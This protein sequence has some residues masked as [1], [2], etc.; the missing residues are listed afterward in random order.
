MPARAAG[1]RRPR[2]R[3]DSILVFGDQLN[4]RMGAL[5]A[6]EPGEATVLLVE[7][8]ALLG[9]GRHVQRNHLVITAMR[10]F[11]R[12]LAAEGFDVDR[13]RAPTVRAGIEAHRA[14]RR[15]DRM[16]ATEPNSRRARALCDTLGIEQVRSDQFL[17]HHDDFARWAAGRKSVRMEDFYR[18]TRSRLG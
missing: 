7:S 5:A 15:P 10:R 17:C 16:V 18:W 11:A 3:G 12:E 4:R 1:D 8:E 14:E 9:I 6:A 13:R 2:P